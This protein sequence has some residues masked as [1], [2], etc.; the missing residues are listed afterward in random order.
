LPRGISIDSRKHP[1]Y[2]AAVYFLCFSE[3]IAMVKPI[4][5]RSGPVSYPEQG[6]THTGS[7]GQTS[8]QHVNLPFSQQNS[9]SNVRNTSDESCTALPSS[10]PVDASRF[11][12]RGG[13]ASLGFLTGALLRVPGAL[14]AGAGDHLEASPNRFARYTGKAVSGVGVLLRGTGDLAGT[15]VTAV[16]RL[17]INTGKILLGIIGGAVG[18]PVSLVDNR[19]LK[20]SVDLIEDGWKTRGEKQRVLSEENPEHQEIV[21]RV[22]PLADILS[23]TTDDSW[24]D[25]NEVD[26]WRRDAS[27]D[28]LIRSFKLPVRVNVFTRDDGETLVA[29]NGVRSAAT[30]GFATLGMFGVDV[31]IFRRA[32]D[33]V[34]AV[35]ERSEQGKQVSERKARVHVTGNSLGG[36]LA[37]YAGILNGTETTCFDAMALSPYLIERLAHFRRAMGKSMADVRVVHIN[38]IGDVLAEKAQSRYIPAGWSQVGERYKVSE[39]TSHYIKPLSRRLRELDESLFQRAK[40][41]T[42]TAQ[43]DASIPMDDRT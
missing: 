39:E 32:G 13:K 33:L 23:Q 37:Q 40:E 26:G 20:K 35:I 18:I 19:L 34:K 11:T 22:A 28:E 6:A 15:A 2:F 10:S 43:P 24:I 1:Q 3:D 21:H 12:T 5:G 30:M 41:A 7:A 8:A 36:G 31:G 42:E 9:L 4:L 38:A 16:E 25:G 14:I 29:F 17:T 27:Y